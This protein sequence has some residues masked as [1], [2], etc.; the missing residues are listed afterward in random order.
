MTLVLYDTSFMVKNNHQQYHALTKYT[1]E[2]FHIQNPYKN[3]DTTLAKQPRCVIF[4]HSKNKKVL[5][6]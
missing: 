5:L 2:E 4:K 3:C 6:Q 1:L